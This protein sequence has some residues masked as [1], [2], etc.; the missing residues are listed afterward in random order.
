V[1]DIKGELTSHTAVWRAQQGHKVD[2][3]DPFRVME[4]NY[5]RLFAKYPHIL[6]SRGFNP[7]HALDPASDDFVD[8]A[9]YLAESLI[10]TEGTKEVHFPQ[11]AQALAKGL[12]MALRVDKS[13]Q[14]DSLVALRLFLGLPPDKMAVCIADYINRLGAKWPAIATSLGEFASYNAEDREIAG[15][16]RTAKIQTD[17]L[18][19][20]LIQADLAR[21][22]AQ[23]FQFAS[24][25]QIPTT[26]YL[27]LPPMRLSSHHVWLRLMV[28]AALMPLLN[29]VEKSPVPVLF[30]LDEVAALQ[31]MPI[32]QDKI[33]VM[34]GFGVKL[35][36]IWQSLNQAKRLYPDSWE[37]FFGT[38][39]GAQVVFGPQ[40]HTTREYFSQLSGERLYNHFM[41][42]TSTGTSTSCSINDYRDLLH[43]H[44]DI[45]VQCRKRYVLRATQ[46]GQPL[47]RLAIQ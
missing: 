4:K 11:G 3:I 24:L 41:K 2:V 43:E 20:P 5:P 8:D 31:H 7:F 38:T 27:I 22:V 37:D 9:K 14:S 25:K 26:V 42:S 12:I 28:T 17:W 40:D 15:I 29:T 10:S 39:A 35:W 46:I 45:V 36:T 6:T 33:A 30:V 44:F 32:I 47:L 23:P 18:D 16:R 34:R 19:S 21:A 13:G 1:I